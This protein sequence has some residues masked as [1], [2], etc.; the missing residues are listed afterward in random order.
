MQASFTEALIHE[1]EYVDPELIFVFGKRAW[2]MVRQQLGAQMVQHEAIDDLKMT[3]VHGH[4]FK[5]QRLLDTHV[6]PLGHMSTNFYGAQIARPE[7]MAGV[8]RGIKQWKGST[9]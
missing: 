1:L 4:L 3:Q 2:R 8:E 5:T 7:Y 6:L 9:P